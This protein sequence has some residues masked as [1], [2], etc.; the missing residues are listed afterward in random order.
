MIKNHTGCDL[1]DIRTLKQ[2]PKN[3]NKHSEEQIDR[4]AKIL[5]YQGWR[6][7]IKVSNR[8]GFITSGHGRLM[9]AQKIP[10]AEVPVNFQDYDSDEQ[11][12]ADIQSDNAIAAWAE[13]DLS[14]IN[15]DIG[16]LGPDFDI[17]LLG[18]KNFTLDISEK[19]Q[20]DE[21]EVPEHVEAITTLG[22]LYRLGDHR[23]L[24]GDSTD[25]LQVEKLM[26][27]EKADMVF[28]DPPYGMSI[29]N[30]DKGPK[31]QIGGYGIEG[32]A[33]RGTYKPVIGDDSIKT[34]LDS[35]NLCRGLGIETLVF[36]GANFYASALPN[37][38]GWLC[39]DKENGEGFFADGELAW[40][41]RE[42]QL[43]I[44]KHQWKGMIKASEM[45]QKRVHPTQK[46]IA[47]A[48]WVFH[49]CNKESKSV[50]DLFGGSG[51]TLIACEKTNRK[52]FMMELDPHYCD[53]IVA[54][55]EKYTGKKAELING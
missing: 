33:K 5:E 40:T 25:I 41:N 26:N 23:L 18:I 19:G 8:S 21:D 51:S 47:L 11:E 9:A 31:N 1:Q 48:E 43:R 29:V 13:L 10:L 32:K 20:C 50:L 6:Y 16:E 45:G 55:W 17:D 30:V 34:A 24:C 15:L 38:S 27:G 35:F 37:S 22:D 12:Y 42:K 52:C 14:G 7:P 36:W 3:R 2:H 44:F 46:P 39:W 49:I 28:T 4:L 53:V 54:R